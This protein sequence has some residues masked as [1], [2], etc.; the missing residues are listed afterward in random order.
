M[1]INE[2]TNNT[3]GNIIDITELK[4]WFY[5]PECQ[6]PLG[7]EQRT[8]ESIIHCL[9][10]ENLVVFMKAEKE[11]A[12]AYPDKASNTGST[13]NARAAICPKCEAVIVCIDALSI[14]V[15]KTPSIEKAEEVP[16]FNEKKYLL[17][18]EAVLLK[19]S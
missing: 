3:N 12:L 2:E 6:E 7:F 9:E 4:L 17:L 15:G 18:K 5:C 1:A 16:P 14:I 8:K 11:K 13:T 10:M 19:R